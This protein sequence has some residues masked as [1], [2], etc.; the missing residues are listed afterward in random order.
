[1]AW[2]ITDLFPPWGDSGSQPPTNKNYQGE[3]QVLQSHLDYLWDSLHTLEQ[4]ARSALTDIDADGDGRV[5]AADDTPLIKGNDIDTDGD[6]IVNDAQ[7]AAETYR[8]SDLD[9]G[10]HT[11]S[12]ATVVTAGGAK[13]LLQSDLADGETIT[14]HDSAIDTLDGSTSNGVIEIVS[15]SSGTA[16]VE[17]TVSGQTSYQNTTGGPQVVGVRF[18]NNATSDIEYYVDTIARQT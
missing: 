12:I 7:D 15:I 8:T 2:S 5:D 14:V 9:T 1:M 16:T 18:T 11:S 17:A 10:Y 6:A 3:E 4:D 13:Y